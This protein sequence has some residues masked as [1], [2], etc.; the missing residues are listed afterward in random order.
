ML[1]DPHPLKTIDNDLYRVC[2]GAKARPKQ[3]VAGEEMRRNRTPRRFIHAVLS[4]R[5][6]TKYNRAI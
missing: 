2:A 4:R 6:E 1:D 5:I 3:E